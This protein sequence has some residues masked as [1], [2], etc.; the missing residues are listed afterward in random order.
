M[1]LTAITSLRITEHS[2]ETLPSGPKINDEEDAFKIGKNVAENEDVTVSSV[3]LLQ[4]FQSDLHNYT[5]YTCTH[6]MGL[7]LSAIIEYSKHYANWRSVF[8]LAFYIF[9]ITIGI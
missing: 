8:S 7:C 1:H 6:C 3:N 9:L 2:L 5:L 4:F